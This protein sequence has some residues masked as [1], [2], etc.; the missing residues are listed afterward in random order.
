MISKKVILKI[1]LIYID[2]FHKKRKIMFLSYIKSESFDLLIVKRNIKKKKIKS[3]ISKAKVFFN[4][5]NKISFKLLT[6]I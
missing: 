2:W 3:P 5:F 4:V 6:K 1:I